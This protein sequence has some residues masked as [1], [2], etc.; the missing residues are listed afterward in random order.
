M[1]RGKATLAWLLISISVGALGSHLLNL[2]FWLC[3]IIVAV[4]LALN[5]WL[6]DREDRGKFNE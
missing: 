4:A 5:G 2:N 1:S 6:A 3:A